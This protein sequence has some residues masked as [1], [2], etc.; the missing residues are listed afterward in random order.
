MSWW[1][2][3]AQEH[4]ANLLCRARPIEFATWGISRALKRGMLETEVNGFNRKERTMRSIVI[5]A[6]VISLIGFTPK[7]R[8]QYRLTRCNNIQ[9]VW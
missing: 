8:A 1:A 7:S 6:I 4:M 9:R 5:S 2:V 3:K